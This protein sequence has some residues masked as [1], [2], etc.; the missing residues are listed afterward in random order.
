MSST[1]KSV[2]D[3]LVLSDLTMKKTTTDR[4]IN[5]VSFVSSVGLTFKGL[6]IGFHVGLG[7]VK[8]SLGLV[9]VRVNLRL[10]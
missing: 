3:D 5:I 7:L 9:T 1:T 6:R 4:K 10:A 2:P 8:V